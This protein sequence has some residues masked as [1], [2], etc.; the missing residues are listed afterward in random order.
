MTSN[1]LFVGT[2]IHCNASSDLDIVENGY[3]YVVNNR[4]VYRGNVQPDVQNGTHII[5][6][7]ETQF[8][9][10]G[11]I[12][13]HIHAPQYSNVGL[14]YDGELIEWLHKYTFPAEAEFENINHANEIYRQVIR[15]TLQ[16][17]TTTACYY[18]TS[19]LQSNLK[20]VEI[21]I[22]LGQRCY[23]GHVNTVP[24]TSEFSIAKAINDTE[25]FIQDTLA[26]K[27]ELVKPIITPRSLLTCS[28]EM[29]QEL[30]KL[31]GT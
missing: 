21:A 31:A 9:I 19:H 7:T 20:L 26:Q 3:L 22:E 12:D 4:I 30:A 17:G 1:Y 23:V 18:G 14:G 15:R 10:P 28:M 5:K 27:S 13:T 25:Y 29:M 8:L 2:T 16:S 11:F 24:S 6:L